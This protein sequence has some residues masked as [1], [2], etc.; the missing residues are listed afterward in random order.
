MLD[1]VVMKTAPSVV[2]AAVA[3][4]AGTPEELLTALVGGAYELLSGVAEADVEAVAAAREAAEALVE[5]VAAL[6]EE[7]DAE[8]EAEPEDMQDGG[9]EE[10]AAPTGRAVTLGADWWGT[11]SLA[12]TRDAGSLPHKRTLD[13]AART[14]DVGGRKMVVASTARVDRY[15]DI[16][17]QPSIRLENYEANPI[18]LWQ[19]SADDVIGNAKDVA[20]RTVGGRPALTFEPAFDEAED[21][22][23]ARRTARQWRDGIL[24]TVSIGF[25]PDYERACA[26]RELPPE[27]WARGE[28]GYYYEGVEITEISVVSVPAN[29]DAMNMPGK[30]VVPLEPKA[31]P[32]QDWW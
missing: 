5:A 18:M 16:I 11:R 26:R 27:H 22:P 7:A 20:V 6:A 30:A 28:T 17:D 8:P 31:A 14:A 25:L 2:A 12:K 3:A 9:E 23:L 32:V 13:V 29:P 24:R 4:L 1:P 15:G 21:N 10:R 19:H